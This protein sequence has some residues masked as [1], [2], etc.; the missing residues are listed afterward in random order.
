MQRRHHSPTTLTLNTG[1]IT[2]RDETLSVDCAILD[3]SGNGACVLVPDAAEIPAEFLLSID[4]TKSTYSCVIRWRTRN[5]IG[6]AFEPTDVV[7]KHMQD[8][9]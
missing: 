2:V 6:V 4:G 9:S 7:G 5:R 1:K 8:L 3:F